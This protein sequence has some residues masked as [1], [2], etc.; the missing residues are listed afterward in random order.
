M[1]ARRVSSIGISPTIVLTRSSLPNED[2]NRPDNLCQPVDADKDRGA[3]GSFDVRVRNWSPQLWTDLHR[4]WI[5]LAILG[6][7]GCALR[8]ED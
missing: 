4:S 3:H 1:S 5:T 2:P 7:A 8:G 6:I